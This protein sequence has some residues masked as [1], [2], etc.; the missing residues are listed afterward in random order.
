MTSPES[1]GLSPRCP[2][3]GAEAVRAEDGPC[4]YV[5]AAPDEGTICGLWSKVC[6]QHRPERFE[7]AH[8]YLG[9]TA[10]SANL[11]HAAL[12]AVSE[13]GGDK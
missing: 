6:V 7:Y 5:Y 4:E 3:C 13:I 11:S 10:C 1:P 8:D 2:V 12:E 9:P